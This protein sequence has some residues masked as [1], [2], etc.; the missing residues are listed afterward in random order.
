MAL[1]FSG[2]AVK[3]QRVSLIKSSEGDSLPRPSVLCIHASMDLA[4]HFQRGLAESW[5]S[6]WSFQTRQRYT[7][8]VLAPVSVAAVEGSCAGGGGGGAGTAAAR[9][10]TLDVLG[11]YKNWIPFV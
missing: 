10:L 5:K 8:Q 11:H 9:R 2:L 6:F 3:S 1:C 7:H 4:W